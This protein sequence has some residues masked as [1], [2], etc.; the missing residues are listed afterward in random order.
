MTPGFLTPTPGVTSR[1]PMERLARAAGARFEAR[2]GWNVAVDYPDAPAGPVGWA[3]LSHLVKVELHDAHGLPLGTAERRGGAWW[4]PVTPARALLIG[5]PGAAVNGE[6][7]VDVTA[8][9][10]A[11]AIVGP[12]ARE[13]IARLSAVDLRPA[14]APVGAFRPVSVA[15]TPAMVLREAEERYLVLFGAALGEYMWTVVADAA[16]HL[17]GGPVGADALVPAAEATRA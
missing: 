13:A 14:V 15:R 2:A 17:G 6:A 8:S 16:T 7:T 5:E 4:C 11:L 10:A 1:S 3:D 12:L 9:Y